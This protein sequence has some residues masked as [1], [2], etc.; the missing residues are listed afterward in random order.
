MLKKLILKKRQIFLLDLELSLKPLE[1]ETSKT[2]DHSI[3]YL[4]QFQS[5][6]HNKAN[7][8]LPKE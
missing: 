8:P 6:Q 7:Y 4:H 1:F 5:Y 2:K 3:M